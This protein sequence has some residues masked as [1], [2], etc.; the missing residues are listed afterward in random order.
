MLTR[1]LLSMSRPMPLQN[2]VAMQMNARVIADRCPA[3]VISISKPQLPAPFHNDAGH[4]R[5]KQRCPPRA[6]LENEAASRTR[7]KSHSIV[8]LAEEEL[9]G[10]RLSS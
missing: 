3:S 7:Q 5:T 8:D 2:L 9:S 1:M 10:T 6:V 4:R